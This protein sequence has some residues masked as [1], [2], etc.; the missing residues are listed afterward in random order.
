MAAVYSYKNV[1][2]FWFKYSEPTGRDGN[3]PRKQW[4]WTKIM[5]DLKLLKKM[6]DNVD[7]QIARE[8]Y[9]DPVEFINHISY[10]KGK[11]FI[12]FSKPTHITRQFR[13]MNGSPRFWD[14]IYEDEH[15]EDKEYEDNN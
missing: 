9:S 7:T 8:T 14:L 5:N 4:T 11:K 3:G 13:K 12:P 1:E 6:T 2:E 15:Q 10:R